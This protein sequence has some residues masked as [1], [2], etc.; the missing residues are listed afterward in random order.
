[1]KQTEEERVETMRRNS[2]SASQRGLFKKIIF[3]TLAVVLI[4][5]F[6]RHSI[7]DKQLTA[8]EKKAT[9]EHLNQVMLSDMQLAEKDSLEKLEE[10]KTYNDCVRNEIAKGEYMETYLQKCNLESES[11]LSAKYKKENGNEHK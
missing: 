11:R 10:E 1:M 9:Q 5:V 2:V 4:L 8:E 7:F 3:V 6:F